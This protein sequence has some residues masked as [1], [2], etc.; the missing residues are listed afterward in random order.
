MKIGPGELLLVVAIILILVGA[1]RMK[2]VS[3]E[4]KRQRDAAKPVRSASPS[5]STSTTRSGLK[6]PQLQLLGVLVMLGG[7]ATMIIG[8]LM[9]QPD[10]TFL[11]LVGIGVVALGI[12]FIILA[13]RR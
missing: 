10:V 5:G 6:Y 13:R 8:Y 7:A 11:S 9:S 3:Q 4:V 12:A 2:A 1:S